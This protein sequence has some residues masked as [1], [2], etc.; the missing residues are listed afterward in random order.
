MFSTWAERERGETDIQTET[1]ESG[2]AREMGERDRRERNRQTEESGG[3]R[4]NIY[5]DLL[6]KWELLL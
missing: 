3:E 5:T 1:E 2:G 6:F 4:Q